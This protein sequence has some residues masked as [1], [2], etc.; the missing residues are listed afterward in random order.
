MDTFEKQYDKTAEE[1]NEFYDNQEA[2]VSTD[3]F[4]SV[5]TDEIVSSIG[6]KKVLDFG[7]GAGKDAAFYW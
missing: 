1:F 7:C 2:H 6:N 5:I 4:F 3:A